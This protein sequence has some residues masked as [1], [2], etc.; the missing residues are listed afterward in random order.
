MY[1]GSRYLSER[2]LRA[3][4]PGYDFVEYR[5]AG[6]KFGFGGSGS[7]IGKVWVVG[8]VGLYYAYPFMRMC[9]YISLL[10]SVAKNSMHLTSIITV[11]PAVQNIGRDVGLENVS[12][13][14]KIVYTWCDDRGV[15]GGQK[16]DSKRK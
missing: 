12:G 7:G 6:R 10:L 5:F 15:I 1:D 8:Q 3:C 13:Q 4:R 16:E 11:E 2:Y 9:I 14:H